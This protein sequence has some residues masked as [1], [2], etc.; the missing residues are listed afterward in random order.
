MVAY[1]RH[2]AAGGTLLGAI[3]GSFAKSPLALTV[4]PL[5]SWVHGV[6]TV[7]GSVSDPFA[8]PDT[9][10]LTVDGH[11]YQSVS[12]SGPFALPL[13]TTVLSQGEHTLTVS[14]RDAAGVNASDE[15]TVGVDN[16][17]P[18]ACLSF[19]QF[20]GASV[21][22]S[23]HWQDLS[24]VVS[25]TLDGAPLEI[26]ATGVWY[27]NMNLLALGPLVLVLNDAAGN[28]RTFSWVANEMVNP[29][30]CSG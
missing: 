22:V 17:P 19:V 9:V 8:L 11:A 30:P 20:L 4:S 29:A 13:D 15:M 12:T 18:D 23:G 10:T 16:A 26:T 7:S 14:A 24:G 21:L 2:I 6:L 3:T 28:S 5:P 27:V 25:G 1:A